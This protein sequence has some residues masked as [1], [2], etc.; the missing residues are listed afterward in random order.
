MAKGGKRYPLLVYN[1][2]L[3]RWSPTL[4]ALGLAILAW[5][6]AAFY[7]GGLAENPLPL[8]GREDGI[9]MLIVG[10]VV[11]AAVFFLSIIGKMAYI[12]LFPAYFRLVTPFLRLNV[13]YK[14]INRTSTSQVAELFPPQSVSGVQRDIIAPISSKTA[15]IIFLNA[16]PM[17]RNVLKLF[18]SPFFF[19]DKTTHF[20]IVV[21]DWMRFSQE[22]ESRRV[23]GG[24]APAKKK[25]T[26]TMGIPSL[27]DDIRKK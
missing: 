1:E 26:S 13:S 5:G 23:G 27:L 8:L 20:V 22:L 16:Y 25:K 11:I 15:I 21:E 4:F 24:S 14:R 19:Y 18:L 7:F 2:V 9:T 12:Q 10:G 17:P 6:G 3:G